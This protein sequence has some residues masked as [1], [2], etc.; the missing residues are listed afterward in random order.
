MN[1]G[2]YTI[3]YK[4]IWYINKII[5]YCCLVVSLICCIVILLIIKLLIIV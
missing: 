4:F 5:N 2:T 1:K 3:N